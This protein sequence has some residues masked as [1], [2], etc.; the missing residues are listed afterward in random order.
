MTPSIYTFGLCG[1]ASELALWSSKEKPSIFKNVPKDPS[2]VKLPRECACRCMKLG[3]CLFLAPCCDTARER[4]HWWSMVGSLWHD[5]PL[6]SILDFYW[7]ASLGQGTSFF[8]AS[9]FLILRWNNTYYKSRAY[10]AFWRA[11]SKHCP[12][13]F[14]LKKSL[15]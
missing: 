4:T 14:F 1:L 5:H 8:W 11:F 6:S 13:I 3:A 12:Q 15:T 9:N 7:L 10:I 2:S